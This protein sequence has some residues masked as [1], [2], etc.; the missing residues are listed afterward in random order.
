MDEDFSVRNE[1]DSL[2][3]P[4]ADDYRYSDTPS[5]YNDIVEGIQSAPPFPSVPVNMPSH[6]DP[7][8]NHQNQM[9][10]AVMRQQMSLIKQQQI[11]NDRLMKLFIEKK[12]NSNINWKYVALALGALV[13]YLIVRPKAA[14]RLNPR[15]ESLLQHLD[16][17]SD[18]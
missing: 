10:D 17:L 6:P 8:T 5:P 12:E 1:V 4:Q 2:K 14:R 15:R 16:E 9:Y 3:P 13:L 11:A 18:Y 7:W